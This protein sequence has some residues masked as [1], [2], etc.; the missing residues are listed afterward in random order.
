MGG[1]VHID[2][3]EVKF[4]DPIKMHYSESIRQN[5][6]GNHECLDSGGSMVASL[7][8]KGIDGRAHNGVEPAA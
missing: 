6:V 4:V 1:A 3:R 8:L 5:L 2:G 7:K